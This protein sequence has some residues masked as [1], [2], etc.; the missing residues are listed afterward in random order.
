[1]NNDIATAFRAGR[2]RYRESRTKFEG[3]RQAGH[4]LQMAGFKTMGA[5]LGLIFGLFFLVLL[6]SIIF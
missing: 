1:M 5:G 3:M 6:V 2:E 4:N